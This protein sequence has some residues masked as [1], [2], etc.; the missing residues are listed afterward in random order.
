MILAFLISGWAAF[1]LV[2][3]AYM[4]DANSI[5]STHQMTNLDHF[6]IDHIVKL[7]RKLKSR[8]LKKSNLQT[9]PL[10]HIVLQKF[11]GMLK[12]QQLMNGTSILVVGYIQHCTITDYHFGMILELA[13]LLFTAHSATVMILH[14]YFIKNPR[15]RWWRTVLMTIHYI[16][17]CVAMVLV[18]HDTFLR[19]FGMSAQCTWWSMKEGYQATSVVKLVSNLFFITYMFLHTMWLLFPKQ[20]IVVAF[21]YKLL[22]HLQ[23]SSSRLHI[24]VRAK[25]EGNKGSS[26]VVLF[27]WSFFS[28]ITYF[29]FFMIFTFIEVVYSAFCSLCIVC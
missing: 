14:E 26:K 12:D 6:I 28:A 9:R 17:L 27:V 22:C 25:L 3:F 4:F 1:P 20:L 19:A 7:R 10:L 16:M 29:I 8:V 11:A 13:Y 18:H 2:L 15:M 21:L 24:R 5:C 23:R